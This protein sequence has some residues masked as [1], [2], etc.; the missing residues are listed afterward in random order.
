MDEE[1]HEAET[2]THPDPRSKSRVVVSGPPPFGDPVLVEEVVSVRMY[3]GL[4]GTRPHHTPLAGLRTPENRCNDA[5]SCKPF[6]DA[7]YA[8]VLVWTN[9]H[10]KVV[11]KGYI[12]VSEKRN[13]FTYCSCILFFRYAL[14]ISVVVADDA[15]SNHE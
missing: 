13:R 6:V 1:D 12:Y 14:D 9:G 7:G 11:S 4:T 10:I 2:Y 15:T 8:W 3:Q 5:K